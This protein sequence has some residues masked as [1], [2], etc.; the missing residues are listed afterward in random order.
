[1]L[2]LCLR[3]AGCSRLPY[4]FDFVLFLFL[5]TCFADGRADFVKGFLQ[6]FLHS[7]LESLLHG[8]LECTDVRFV[9]DKLLK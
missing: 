4:L 1:M 5:E 3:G 6:G 7:P 9:L 8:R 2:V